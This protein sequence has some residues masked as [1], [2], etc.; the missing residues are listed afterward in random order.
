MESCFSVFRLLFFNLLLLASSLLLRDPGPLI[1]ASAA[2][3]LFLSV[4]RFA[5][6]AWYL[7]QRP[8]APSCL[9]V[10]PCGRSQDAALWS[11]GEVVVFT[12]TGITSGIDKLTNSSGLIWHRQAISSGWIWHRQAYY[13]LRFD[14]A[15]I[16]NRITSLLQIS[17]LTTL[18]K[19]VYDEIKAPV[20][21]CCFCPRCSKSWFEE[22]F[23]G[24]S[25][26]PW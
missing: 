9:G 12:S 13:F 15:S 25:L 8:V 22:N 14:L 23:E 26:R 19:A 20:R 16:W 2:S 17:S 11:G 4:P 5:T 6:P 10:Q 18:A 21:L 24:Y 1:Q 3:P 7:V